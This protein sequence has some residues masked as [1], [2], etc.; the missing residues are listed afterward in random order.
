MDRLAR[1]GEL[2]PTLSAVLIFG[3]RGASAELPENTLE[4]FQRALEL[5]VDVLETDVHVTRDGHVVVHHDDTGQRMSREPRAVRELDLAELRGW[6]AG[7]GFSGRRRPEDGERRFS[8][9]T[10]AEV[11][12]ALPDAQL[13]VDIKPRDGVAAV[14][15]VI[16]RAQAHERVLLTSFHDEVTRAVRAAGYRGRTGLARGGVLRA[17]ALPGWAPRALRPP[18]DRLQIPVALGPLR[19]ARRATVSRLQRLGLRVDFWVVNEVAVARDVLASGAD[20]LM[21]D[22]PRTIVPS[23]RGR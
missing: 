9:P 8:V 2:H 5:G 1:A 13:N 20:G 23:I 14:L 18:G 12:E 3:H 4:A 11:L 10:F 19:L 6:D 21:T 15:R 7:R 22:D 16:E 17:L